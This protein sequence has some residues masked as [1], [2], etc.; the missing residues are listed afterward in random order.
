MYRGYQVANADHLSALFVRRGSQ[1][2]GSE[3]PGPARSKRQK[4]SEQMAEI[5]QEQKRARTAATTPEQFARPPRPHTE[6]VEDE[7][8]GVVHQPGRRYRRA[9]TGQSGK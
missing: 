9:V 8:E 6:D 4:P 3:Q 1:A 5:R 2:T 7:N